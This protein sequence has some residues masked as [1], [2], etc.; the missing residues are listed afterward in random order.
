[1]VI[2]NHY[3]RKKIQLKEQR[4]NVVYDYSSIELNAA[5][6]RVLNRGLNFCILPKRLDLTQVLVDFRRFKR[7]MVWKKF[8][9][10]REGE[11]SQMSRIFKK[12]KNNFPRNYRSPQV[13]QA[14]LAAVKSEPMDPQN[15]HK[16]KCNIPPDEIEALIKLIQLQKKKI[17]NN[18]TM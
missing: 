11:N 15:K 14:F 9:F 8:W 16:V 4:L 17:K 12:K 18:K 13:L 3:K 1:M 6:D 2:K 5:M 7:T 10:G